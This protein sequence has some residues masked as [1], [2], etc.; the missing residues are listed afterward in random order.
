[1]SNNQS[2]VQ[3]L[4]QKLW[5]EPKDKFT[6]N[7]ILKQMEQLHKAE[8]TRAASRGYL[9]ASDDLPLETATGYGNLY[10][11]SQFNYPSCEGDN[12]NNNPGTMTTT[13]E[14]RINRAMNNVMNRMELNSITNELQGVAMD[15]TND[16]LLELIEEVKCIW[17]R[18]SD[19]VESRI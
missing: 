12:M 15:L 18:Y 13:D 7:T 17:E 9:A 5:D 8:I 6:W 14:T 4:F 2:S 3:Q 10:Y 1:M 11:A 19:V 16:E